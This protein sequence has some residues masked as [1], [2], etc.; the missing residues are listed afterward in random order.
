LRF[1]DKKKTNL[2]SSSAFCETLSN[3]KTRIIYGADIEDYKA[4]AVTALD[5][6]KWDQLDEINGV[7]SFR[8]IP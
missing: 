6:K 5:P 8:D 1:C 2:S 3:G 7:S 4:I